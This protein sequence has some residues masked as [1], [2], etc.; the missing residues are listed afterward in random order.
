MAQV[1]LEFK[2]YRVA[3]NG[4]PACLNCLLFSSLQGTVKLP[5]M[6]Q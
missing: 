1:Q 6:S 5:F 2:N 3:E 4:Y